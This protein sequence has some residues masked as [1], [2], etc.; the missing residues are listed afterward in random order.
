[1]EYKHFSQMTLNGSELDGVKIP[2]PLTVD[3]MASNPLPQGRSP[4]NPHTSIESDFAALFKY[5]CLLAGHW[6]LDFSR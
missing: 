5:S 1:M 6:V 4:L 3:L 2:A